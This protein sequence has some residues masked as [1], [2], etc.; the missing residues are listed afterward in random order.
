MRA[1][2]TTRSNRVLDAEK[3]VGVVEVMTVGVRVA[4]R[5]PTRTDLRFAGTPEQML[6]LSLGTVLIYLNSHLAVRSVA[7]AWG[8]AAPMARS[9]SP[10]LPAPRRPVM[11]TGPWS[12]TTIIRMFGTPSV[13]TLLLAAQPGTN[14]P[15]MLRIQVGPITWDLADAAAYT[16]LLNAWR[17]AADLLAATCGETD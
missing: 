3:A 2:D 13:D 6:G 10:A 1:N 14:L 15:T 11:A 7:L 12:L 4:G 9:L 17:G 5:V 8:Q 16:S